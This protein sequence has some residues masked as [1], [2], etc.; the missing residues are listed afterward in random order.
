MLLQERSDQGEEVRQ[1]T[2]SSRARQ[3]IWSVG[4]ERQQ[5]A[6]EHSFS[7]EALRTTAQSVVA[8][9]QESRE[10]IPQSWGVGALGQAGL[11][12]PET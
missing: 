9:A 4:L 8:G 3:R 1:Q 7:L 6:Q 11:P 2:G 10:L 5:G 12:R